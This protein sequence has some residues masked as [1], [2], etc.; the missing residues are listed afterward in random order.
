MNKRGQFGLGK[1]L[2]WM[3]VLIEAEFGET[4]NKVKIQEEVCFRHQWGNIKDNIKAQGC[5]E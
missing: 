3:V 5:Q 2:R 4:I 1:E